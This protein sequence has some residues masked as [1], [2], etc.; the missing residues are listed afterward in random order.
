MQ[1][2]LYTKMKVEFN[3]NRINYLLALYKMSME[4]MVS[5]LNEGRK[6]LVKA[7]DVCGKE[8]DLA[9]LKRID[10]LFDKGLS[11]YFDYS[12]LQTS[13]GSS[14]FFRK[15]EFGTDLNKESIHVVHRF[16]TLKQ[17]LDAYNKLSRLNVTCDIEHC[18]INDDPI[19]V[20]RKAR[21]L[22]YPGQLKDSRKFLVE[23][24]S[25]CAEYNVFV[26]EYVET[27]NKKDKTNIDG[28]FLRPNMI[29]LKHHKHY[30]REIFTLAHELGHCYLGEEEVEQVDMM[31][32]DANTKINSVERWCNDFAYYFVMG[33]KARELASI[34]TVDASND[35]C[36]DF[37]AALSA[38]TH[39]SRLAIFTR[40]YLERKMTYASYSNV[41][42]ELVGQYQ[43]RLEAEKQ[44]NEGKKGGMTPK[45]IIS[46]LFL[47]IMQYAYFKGVINEGTFCS[48]LNINPSKFEKTLWQ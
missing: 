32:I 24:I 12:P 31:S 33:E 14:V 13:A 47:K 42:A 7:S 40:L 34:E 26:F 21:E 19:E 8:I 28:F 48:K 36:F 2:V 1:K 35:Y 3:I 22:F 27:W 15:S 9:L 4:E 45:P 23:L 38:E 20:A 11:F 43:L 39:I 16:E 46:P 44:K 25:K 17:A 29:V 10:K 6:R 37:V 30:K 5:L 18:S 41:R